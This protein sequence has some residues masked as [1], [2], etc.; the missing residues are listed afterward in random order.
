MDRYSGHKRPCP[1]QDEEDSDEV[2]QTDAGEAYERR[3]KEERQERR[4]VE[5]QNLLRAHE[6]NNEHNDD[7]PDHEADEI[8]TERSALPEAARA[9]YKRGHIRT[10]AHG[11]DARKD[12]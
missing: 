11:I 4:S 3:K 2:L 12:E 9:P 6:G 7:V 1:H 8:T 10:E 5:G